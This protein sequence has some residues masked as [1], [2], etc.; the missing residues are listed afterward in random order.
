M[1]LRPDNSLFLMCNNKLMV[2]SA[3]IKNVYTDNKDL[4]GFLYFFLSKDSTFG[5]HLH[6]SAVG[7][8]LF[9]LCL[10]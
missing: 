4:D 3:P 1:K 7:L 5:A 6:P 2:T 9:D 10:S 8:Q